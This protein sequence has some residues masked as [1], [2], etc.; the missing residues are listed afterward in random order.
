MEASIG[1]NVSRR[2]MLHP[3][4]AWETIYKLHNM[5]HL[6]D[7]HNAWCPFKR[8][9]V[10]KRAYLLLKKSN[11]ALNEPAVLQSCCPI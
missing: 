9:A 5:Q 2:E 6:T 3:S 1:H 4:L 10:A 11:A 7:N 8:K